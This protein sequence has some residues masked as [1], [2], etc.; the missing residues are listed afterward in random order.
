MQQGPRCNRGATGSPELG[1][2][3]LSPVCRGSGS[4]RGPKISLRFNPV[5]CDRKVIY[6]SALRQSKP[7]F[8]MAVFYISFPTWCLV[9]YFVNWNESDI[10]VHVITITLRRH[11]GAGK[12]SSR[13]SWPSS[14]SSDLTRDSST[15]CCRPPAP[16]PRL[17]VIAVAH[18]L[19]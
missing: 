15:L 11:R 5:S 3:A 2:S 13:E 16:R 14:A 1:R 4:G 9:S 7:K 8:G 10:H 19:Y 12:S 6:T 17:L 18:L